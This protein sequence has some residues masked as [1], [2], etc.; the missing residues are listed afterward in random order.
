MTDSPY[1]L[2]VE[3][4]AITETDPNTWNAIAKLGDCF[5]PET[6]ASE[7]K[8]IA[9]GKL[10]GNE[11]I[12]RQFQGRLTELNWQ[13]TN[14]SAKHPDLLIRSTQNLSRK[15]KLLNN[16]AQSAVGL[17]NANPQQC[18]ILISDEIALRDRIA[19]LQHNHLCAIPSAIARQWSRTNQA[20]PIVKQT[21][22]QLENYLARQPLA[23]PPL[24]SAQQTVVDLNKL[25][26][27]TL[28]TA[29]FLKS[30]LPN[31][32][33]VATHSANYAQIAINI[34]KSGLAILFFIAL[35]LIGWRLIQPQ[36]F[37]QFWDKTGLPPLPKL[38]S[39]P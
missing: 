21:L 1:L 26:N 28:N 15:A 7:L 38:S 10:E 39:L 25:A 29:D 11:A 35:I 30:E 9:E 2:L 5:L 24:T 8:H 37:Q 3:T 16:V 34:V 17:A 23:S 27:S 14:I 32:A 33:K 22:K 31:R 6:V 20:P 36:Q 13:T 19:K 4:S 18:V 12:A